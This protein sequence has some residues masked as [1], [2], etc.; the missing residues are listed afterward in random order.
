[1]SLLQAFCFTTCTASTM[2]FGEVPHA[3]TDR[4]RLWVTVSIRASVIIGWACLLASPLSLD[5]DRAVRREGPPPG[6]RYD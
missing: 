3:F 4:P 6:S 1:M 5:R 2:G